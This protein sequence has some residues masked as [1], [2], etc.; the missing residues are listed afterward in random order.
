MTVA[1][2]VAVAHEA[3]TVLSEAFDL[4]LAFVFAFIFS[5]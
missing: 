1:V 3:R 5:I 4:V 2:A